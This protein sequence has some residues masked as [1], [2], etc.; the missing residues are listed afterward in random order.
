MND[1][2]AR[3]RLL[4]PAEEWWTTAST[5]DD[6]SAVTLLQTEALGGRHQ[7]SVYELYSEMEE[8]DGHLLSFY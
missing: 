8:K 4:N 3:G 7:R 5:R 1:A 2:L 6:R